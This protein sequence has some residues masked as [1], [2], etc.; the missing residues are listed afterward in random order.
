VLSVDNLLDLPRLKPTI[1]RLHKAAEA[2]RG[3]MHN[4]G[5][6]GLF[7]FVFMPF[8]MTGP[9]VGSI[10]GYLL[11]IRPWVNI[12]VV[13]SATCIAIGLW[14]LLLNELSSW[15]AT[16]NHLA[17][18]GLVGAAALIVLGGYVWQRRKNGRRHNAR[19]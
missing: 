10:I 6:V 19:A 9:V 17:P 14:G 7:V 15:A 3:K 18:F 11:G 2:S 5:Y 16:Y 8:W 4:L 1:N 12:A 13:L